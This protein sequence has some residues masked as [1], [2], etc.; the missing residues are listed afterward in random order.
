MANVRTD[1]H[2]RVIVITIDRP[3]RRNA[4]LDHMIDDIRASIRAASEDSTVG[5]LVITGIDGS[6]CAGADLNS[7]VDKA[8]NA[9]VDTREYIEEQGQGIVR[10]LIAL[11][12][13]TIAAV[14]GPAIG[15][16]FDI[17]LACDTILIGPKGWCMQGWG[18]VGLIDGTGGTLLLKSRAP[19]LLWRLLAEQPRITAELGERWGVAENAGPRLALDVALERLRSYEHLTVPALAHYVSA[20]RRDIREQLPAYLK[21]TAA[22]QADLITSPEFAALARTLIQQPKG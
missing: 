1:R 7:A 4:L 21:T 17:A 14:D 20:Q 8:A 18:R 16:G 6:F 11:D 22:V 9:D 5:G 10:D 3:E 2:G 15:M 13:P 12:V 19:R